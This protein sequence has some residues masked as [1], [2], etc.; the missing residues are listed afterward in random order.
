MLTA[1]WHHV[2][3]DGVTQAYEVKGRGPVCFVHAGGPGIDSD[4]MR[5]PLL[6]KYMTLVYLDPVG[7][8]RS[9]F[10]PDGDYSVAEYARRLELLRAHLDVTDGF[11]MGHSHGG[12]VALQHALD[13]PGRLR[14]LIVYASAPTNSPELE[15]EARRQIAAFA[16]RWPDRPE[17]VEAVRIFE[18][19]LDGEVK[20]TDRYSFQ[21]YVTTL[22]PA[23]F[24]DFRRTTK[25][26]GKPPTLV[27]TSYDP[28][29][30]GSE[31]DVRGQLGAIETPTLTLA[32]T[33]DFTCPP[34]WSREIHTEI[35][36]SQLVEFTAS[37][38]FPHIEQ[39]EQFVMSIRGYL[40]DLISSNGA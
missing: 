21:E 9:G 36:G 32:G 11:V 33:Y 7:T 31:F 27:I 5:M 1:G 34:M 12:F 6:E 20:I 29:R 3:L 40:A 15:A 19:E 38:H 23:F 37:G 24:A 16:E 39:P 14:G 35:T 26:L 4:Y 30:K 8:G 17:A 18:A 25:E 2:E 28:D 22:M 13:Y 10:L